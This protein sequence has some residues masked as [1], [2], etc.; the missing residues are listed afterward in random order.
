MADKAHQDEMRVR[1]VTL[2]EVKELLV[3]EQQSRAGETMPQDLSY[4]QKLAL[5]HADH[6]VKLTP[7]KSRE[8]V[9]RLVGLGGRMTEYY[10]F[11]FADILPTHAD[12][13]KAVYAR[14]RSSPD[15]GEIE[16][17]LATVR[18]YL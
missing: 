10:A 4:E 15:E 8:L 18:D 2:S 13:V 11:R 9:K 17:I 6:F 12:D 3:K 1:P 14:E 16:K 7:D 5:D